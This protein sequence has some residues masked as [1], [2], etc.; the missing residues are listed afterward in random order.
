MKLTGSR[1]PLNKPVINAL[2]STTRPEDRPFKKFFSLCNR[3]AKTAFS[4]LFR[5]Q[6]FSAPK[7]PQKPGEKIDIPEKLGSRSVGTFYIPEYFI[8]SAKRKSY[9]IPGEKPHYI[10]QYIKCLGGKFSKS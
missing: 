2:N 4:Q 5:R 9:D 6:K 1:R 3:F 7:P 8:C 10:Y